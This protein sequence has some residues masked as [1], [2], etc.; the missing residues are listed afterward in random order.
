MSIQPV[1]LC[2]GSGTRLW[3]LSR[4]LYPKQLIN[5][6]GDE[7]LLQSTVRRLHGLPDCRPPQLICNE[8]HRFLVAEQMRQMNMEPGSILLEP[9]GK[10]TAPA[11]T[12][13]ALSAKSGDDILLTMPADHVIRDV[14]VFHDAVTSGVKWL[15]TQ[16]DTIVTFGIVPAGIETGY[17][18]IQKARILEDGVFEVERFVEK[19]DYETAKGYVE[20][21]DFLWNSGIFM[22]TAKAWLQQ[23]E[24][25]AP[26]MA[27]VCQA[28]YEKR[29]E[30]HDFIRVHAETFSDCPADSIDYAVVEKTQNPIVVIP[31]D[32]G[33]SDVGA[34]S[35]LWEISEQDD[36]GNV[37]RGDVQIHDVED[38]LLFADRRL[39]SAVG[40][41]D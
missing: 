19:P 16:P 34:W 32:A 39:V 30:E 2:G 25:L 10:N 9:E 5:L 41:R 29:H 6:V 27:T 20:S 17:G 28:A 1:I 15:S 31:L 7:S 35:S 36:N 33:W 22:I 13:A 18:Y 12:L 24:K 26:G 14:S 21:G 38:S 37:I 4:E 40:V 11:L 3:P 8:E 23:V